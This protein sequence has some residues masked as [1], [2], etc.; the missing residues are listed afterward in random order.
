MTFEEA[1]KLLEKEGFTVHEVCKPLAVPE[2]YVR[3]ENPKICKAMRVMYSAGYSVGMEISLFDERK[4]RLK[5]EYEDNGN[6]FVA[7]TEVE[8]EENPAL[9]ESASQFNDALLDEQA[10]EIKRLRKK[11]TR[12]GKIIHKK[13]LKIDELRK[14]SS[15]HLDGKM[16]LF[17]ENVDLEQMV[18]DKNAVL[19]DVAE[20]L[21]LSK[22][23]EKNLV[24]SCQKYMKEY[25]ELKEKYANGVVDRTNAQALKSAESA[26]ADKE[27]VIAGKDEEI[28]NLVKDLENTSNLL[29]E[30]R[31]GS[32]EYCEYGIAAEKMI[33]KL[34]KII[35]KDKPIST[36]EFEKCRRWANGY[37]F[38]PLLP[39]LKL[40]EL[41]KEEEEKLEHAM[42]YRISCDYA[43]EGADHS[44]VIVLCGKDFIDAPKRPFRPKSIEAVALY[45]DAYARAENKHLRC[46]EWKND[47]KGLSAT[48][49]LEDGRKSKISLEFAGDEIKFFRTVQKNKK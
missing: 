32:D 33:Q 26:L 21:R 47:G 25:E 45:A 3:Y 6:A 12:M 34:A 9:K 46:I 5:K 41:S 36:K 40:P 8:K 17:G 29:A 22:I 49:I 39:E 27:K 42:K 31:K 13:N 10:K 24:E 28:A 48:Y 14:E 37:R 4:A 20:E 1:K 15:R 19:S 2:I 11:I 7:R 44:G 16:K 23:R 30:V 35:V 38:N 18:K 43:E